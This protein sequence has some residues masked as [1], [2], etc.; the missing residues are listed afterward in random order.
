M[1]LCGSLSIAMSLA[2]YPYRILE[3]LPIKHLLLLYQDIDRCLNYS[4]T[5]NSLRVLLNDLA[6]DVSV[7]QHSCPPSVNGLRRISFY[8]LVRLPFQISRHGPLCSH[9]CLSSE[10]KQHTIKKSVKSAVNVEYSSAAYISRFETLSKFA[11]LSGFG[12]I[13]FFK[14][15]SYLDVPRNT[16]CNVG[17]SSNVLQNDIPDHIYESILNYIK[18]YAEKNIAIEARV[19]FFNEFSFS[20]SV[21]NFRCAKIGNIK[22]GTQKR[23]DSIKSCDSICEIKTAKYC[24]SHSVMFRDLSASEREGK[25]WYPLYGIVEQIYGIRIEGKIHYLFQVSPVTCLGG[26]YCMWFVDLKNKKKSILLHHSR[27]IQ[28]SYVLIKNNLLPMDGCFAVGSVGKGPCIMA[29][30]VPTTK[31]FEIPQVNELFDY[32]ILGPT[33]YASMSNENLEIVSKRVLSLRKKAKALG[34]YN[35]FLIFLLFRLI[36]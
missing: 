35:F 32:E 36:L 28:R 30:F 19:Q 23:D 2:S 9:S 12:E 26:S 11:N 20:N 31:F 27:F 4:H 18:D 21:L 13:S 22:I 15:V 24:E 29:P 14:N 8:D 10:R 3:C 6:V 16:V 5:K 17:L 7:I 1:M 33:R 34:V 25:D